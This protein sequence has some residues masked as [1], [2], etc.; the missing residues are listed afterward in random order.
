MVNVN[1]KL[2]K[3]IK[4]L[5]TNLINLLGSV[6]LGGAPVSSKKVRQ[7]I[8]KDVG[9]TNFKYY[10]NILCNKFN[11]FTLFYR[12]KINPIFQGIKYVILFIHL[13]TLDFGYIYNA[14][15]NVFDNS[16]SDTEMNNNSD[17]KSFEIN[18]NSDSE[19]FV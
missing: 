2:G 11:N 5:Y 19:D 12:N 16:N 3:S 10:F 14:I 8:S 7:N 1:V 9:K 6:S 13:L 17:S 18:N 15:L 4:V